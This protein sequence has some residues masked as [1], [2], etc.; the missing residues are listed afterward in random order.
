MFLW[1]A[2]ECEICEVVGTARAALQHHAEHRSCA[3]TR[4]MC[5]LREGGSHR[6]TANDAMS[7]TRKVCP[8][9]NSQFSQLPVI[10][11]FHMVLVLSEAKNS[12]R[13]Q[14]RRGNCN[15]AV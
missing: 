8:K 2:T 12:V 15:K 4:T 6:Q 14:K 1:E 5:A 11:C 3:I 13:L 9:T 7:K 10:S